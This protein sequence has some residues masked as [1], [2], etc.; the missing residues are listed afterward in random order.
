[1]R[2]FRKTLYKLYWISRAEG[3]VAY[4]KPII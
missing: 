3:F 2:I 1:M 4:K